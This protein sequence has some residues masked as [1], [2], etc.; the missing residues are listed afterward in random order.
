MDLFRSSRIL[1]ADVERLKEKKRDV[2]AEI[3]IG[4]FVRGLPHGYEQKALF[5]AKGD[6]PETQ[7]AACLALASFIEERG[8]DLKIWH[9]LAREKGC[10]IMDLPSDPQLQE[11]QAFAAD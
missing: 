11:L 6:S 9:D 1:L 3:P 5:V 4:R 7:L 8:L 2:V 10:L